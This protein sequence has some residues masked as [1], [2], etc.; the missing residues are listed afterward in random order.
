MSE[1]RS[2]YRPQ[3]VSESLDLKLN[4]TQNAINRRVLIIY[5][6][7]RKTVDIDTFQLLI[8]NSDSEKRT[9]GN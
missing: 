2:P 5:D 7:S 3:L 8:L 6:G 9:K 4:I 1:Q